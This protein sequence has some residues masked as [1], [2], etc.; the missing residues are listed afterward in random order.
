MSSVMDTWHSG[1]AGGYR[2]SRSPDLHEQG[3]ATRTGIL[4]L[5]AE[6]EAHLLANWAQWEHV[7]N[8]VLIEMGR[9]PER[10]GDSDEGLLPPTPQAVQEA[11][12]F[13]Q[14]ARSRG[15]AGPGQILPDGDGGIVIQ[16]A[17]PEGETLSFEASPGGSASL[18]RYRRP[19][20][21]PVELDRRE[22]PGAQE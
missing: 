12:R 19:P 21:P 5:S 16:L 2:V 1:T 20:L 11:V 9:D 4:R 18:W 15:A 10:F 7:I 22:P 8:N 13:A 3:E 17:L 14:F 6:E